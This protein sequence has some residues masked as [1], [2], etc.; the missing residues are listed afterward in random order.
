MINRV[1]TP[2]ISTPD[3]GEGIGRKH[4]FSDTSLLSFAIP[5]FG[6]KGATIGLGASI[7]IPTAGDNE[8]TG[9]GQWQAGPA[10][11][12]INHATKGLQWG[13]LVFQNW[14]V[15]ST[16]SDA[17]DVSVLS[18]QPILTKHFAGGWYVGAPDLAQT[19]DFETN[20]WSLN[21][22]AQV[23]RVFGWRK[24]HLQIFGAVYYNSEDNDD[25]IASEWTAKVNV[26][27]LLPE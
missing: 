23:G 5:D 27:F 12:Y 19:Y 20:E 3:L 10:A 18:I 24:Q 14:D 9:S 6:M 7:G 11:V 8:Y 17:A 25:I 16:R 21:L 26:S 1:T 22:G 2:Y 13:L 4:G 15:A